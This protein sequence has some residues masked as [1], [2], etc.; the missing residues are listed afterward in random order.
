[1]AL[2]R[3]TDRLRIRPLIGVDQKSSAAGKTAQMTLFGNRVAEGNAQ[4]DYGMC[5]EDPTSSKLRLAHGSR[6]LHGA[7]F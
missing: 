4:H 3:H 7:N 1:M 6:Y 2:L 5:P